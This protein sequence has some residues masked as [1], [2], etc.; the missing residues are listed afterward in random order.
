MH[1]ISAG[2]HR[3]PALHA[4]RDAGAG[5]GEGPRGIKSFKPSLYGKNAADLSDLRYRTGWCL[6]RNG[7]IFGT[8]QADS[9]DLWYGTG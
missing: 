4:Q 5:P 8:D 1:F 6:V 3:A 9:A 7:L 2:R